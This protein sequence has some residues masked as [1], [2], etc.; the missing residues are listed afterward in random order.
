MLHARRKAAAPE[1]MPPQRSHGA[2]NLGVSAAICAVPAIVFS[3]WWLAGT[4][5]L[6]LASL[7]SRPIERRHHAQAMKDWSRGCVCLDCGASFQSRDLDVQANPVRVRESEA[8]PD[9]LQHS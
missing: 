3:P 5:V 9:S 8:W 6:G 7:T 4:A 1:A 2:F